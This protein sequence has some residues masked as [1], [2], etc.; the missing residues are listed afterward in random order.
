M[1]R[2]INPDDLFFILAAIRWTLLLSAFAIIGGGVIAVAVVACR[3]T[4]PRALQAAGGV[5]VFLFQ[6]VPPLM[7]LF[8][9]F[10]GGG[11]FDIR[12]EPWSAAL[13]AFSL[14]SSAYLAEIWESAIRAVPRHQWESAQALSFDGPRMLA[15]IIIPQAVPVAIPPTVAF[16]V[17][18][19]KTT[20]L[21]S[22]I[23]FIE[24]VR[25][26]Q[27]ISNATL[28]PLPVYAFVSAIYFMLCWPLSLWAQA[29][30]VRVARKLQRAPL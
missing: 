25:A 4:R 6:A 10:Y 9:V 3:L 27:L 26:S 12:L 18:L 30:E 20:S 21:A 16:L 5:Y 28:R 7:L 2:P 11:L 14:F 29:L 19:I 1:I 22:I 8:L 24:L 15:L 13:V 23:G 17:N